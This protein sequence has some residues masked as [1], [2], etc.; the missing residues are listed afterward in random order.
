MRLYLD[1]MIRCEVAVRLRQEG[2]DVLRAAEVGQARSDDAS[3]MEHAIADN[4]I[5]VT[6]DEHFGNWAVLPLNRHPG[7]IRL[8]IH[9]PTPD[10]LVE[11]LLPFLRRHSQEQFCER[12]VI[13]GMRR[14]RWICT[15]RSPSRG[16]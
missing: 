8:K 7:V 1:Q 14:E 6:L 3:I 2:H 4:R 12:L 13:A 9:P 10:R 16:V 5:L 15:T 11:F